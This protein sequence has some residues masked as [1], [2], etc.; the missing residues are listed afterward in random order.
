[1]EFEEA[2]LEELRDRMLA[3]EDIESVLQKSGWKEF[4]NIIADIFSANGFKV[5][6]NF[7]FETKRRYEIDIVCVRQKGGKYDIAVCVDC[8]Q[9]SGG[10]YK[11]SGLKN[12]VFSQKERVGE[13]K[14]FLKGNLIAQKRFGICKKCKFY[15][16]V[17]TLLE[18]TILEFEGCFIVPVWKLNSF[19]VD[20]E[21]YMD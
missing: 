19:L 6:Q 14:K 9:W 15:P 5:K 18:E 2:N 8:K 20:F 1:M 16:L 21:K 11:N 13:L 7:R 17:I 12:A 10:R 4:E 3:G